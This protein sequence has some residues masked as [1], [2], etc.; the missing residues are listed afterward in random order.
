MQLEPGVVAK[1]RI[2]KIEGEGRRSRAQLVQKPLVVIAVFE[3]IRG[4]FGECGLEARDLIQVIGGE[5]AAGLAAI[6]QARVTE[7]Y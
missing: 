3:L 5:T 2:A 6:R 7:Q 1:S 4:K